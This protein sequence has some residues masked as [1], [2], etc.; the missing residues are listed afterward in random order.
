MGPGSAPADDDHAFVV[1]GNAAPARADLDHL[2][3][4][5][6][7]GQSATF[8]VAHKIDLERRHDRRHT[9]V[10]SAELRGCTAHVEG[11]D[12]IAV[13]LLANDGRHEDSSRRPG[14]D[15]AHWEISG[16][17]RSDQPAIRLHHKQL[18]ADASRLERLIQMAQ[19]AIDDGFD[20]G[21]GD[22]CIA[23]LVL[24]ELWRNL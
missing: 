7:D 3:G 5:H 2:D 17:A 1:A 19:V 8:L 14:L 10:D 6:V 9:I 13:L 23:T 24:T 22:C 16:Q 21:V 11:D 15:D 12:L 20:V 4:W 18:V